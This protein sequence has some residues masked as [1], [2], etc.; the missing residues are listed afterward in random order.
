[1]PHKKSEPD[2]V[3]LARLNPIEDLCT[4]QSKFFKRFK[5][6]LSDV[7]LL[8]KIREDQLLHYT[9]TIEPHE[10]WYFEKNTPTDMFILDGG[11]ILQCI[12]VYKH[13]GSYR[14]HVSDFRFYVQE[15]P[16]EAAE[17]AGG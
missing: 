3:S 1:M 17:F 13:N 5:K 6:N 10:Q 16:V 2:L 14:Y 4:L 15:D 9:Q 12:P 11:R 7:Q 8:R